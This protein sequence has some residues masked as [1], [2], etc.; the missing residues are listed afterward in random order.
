MTTTNP[1]EVKDA[2]KQA[3]GETAATAKDEAGQVASAASSAASDVAG[4]AKEQAGA[5]AGQAVTEFKDLLD[6]T[7]SQVNEQAGGASKQLGASL[8][9][10]TGQIRAMGE[11][12]ADG[13]GPAAELARTI[14]DKGEAFA[15]M[16]S[17]KEPGELVADLR[18]YAARNPGTFLLG[19]LAAGVVAGRF[20]RGVKADSDSSP[21]TASA[22][23]TTATSGTAG[24][25]TTP[26]VSH[27]AFRP[28][29]GS[30]LS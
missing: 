16:L 21:S 7:M 4:T 27:E 15:Q 19:A 18:G 10:L 30:G 29:G 25:A 20:V 14:A 5:V 9:D 28:A 3:A 11:G 22:P 8:G 2:G 13:S 1:S 12:S 24:T 6:Q 17:S 23:S 26:P